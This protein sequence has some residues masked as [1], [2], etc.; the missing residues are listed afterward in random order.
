MDEAGSQSPRRASR[1]ARLRSGL[2]GLDILVGVLL[3]VMLLPLIAGP[4]V[5]VYEF[6]KAGA[7]T[8]AGVV[9]SVFAACVGLVV[10]AV[11][12]GEF[13]PGVF[14][15]AVALVMLMLFMATRLPS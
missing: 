5:L 1:L 11:R 3:G 10:R 7:Y 14:G 2:G 6:A 13:G 8:H 12:R 4:F 9:G 15:A